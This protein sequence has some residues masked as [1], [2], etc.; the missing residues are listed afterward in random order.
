MTRDHARVVGA[1]LATLALVALFPHTASARQS[2]ETTPDHGALS[3]TLVPKQIGGEA[4]LLRILRKTP[5]VK[6]AT[7]V[8]APSER[9]A[10]AAMG[11]LLLAGSVRVELDSQATFEKLIAATA[12]VASVDRNS[13]AI[14]QATPDPIVG[15]QWG[16][17]NR[18]VPQGIFLDAVSTLFVPAIIGEDIHLPDTTLADLKL[19]I[20]AILDTGADLDHPDLKDSFARKPGECDTLTLYQACLKTETR[21]KCD[22][23]YAKV[24]TDGNGYPMDCVG[25]NLTAGPN[26]AT[27]VLGDPNTTDD[28]GHGTHLAGIIAATAGN[29]LGGRGAAPN[30]RILPVKVIRSAPNSPIRP[31]ADEP[32]LPIEATLRWTQGFADIIARGMLYAIRSGAQVINMSLAWPA[33]VDSAVMRRMVALAQARGILVV[34]AAGNDSTDSRVLPCAYPGVVCV[35]SH[36]SDG[37]FSHFSNYGS[38]I[39]LSAPGTRILSTWP[40]ALRAEVYTRYNGFELKSGTSMAAPYVAAAAAMLLG[41]G[42]A[43]DEVYA[44]LMT[45]TR[46]VRPSIHR[47]EDLTQ[48]YARSGNLDIAGAIAV[49]A[50]PLILPS[51]KSVIKAAWDR[52]ATE[53]QVSLKLRNFWAHADRVTI[54]ARL[55]SYDSV[56]EGARGSIVDSATSLGLSLVQTDFSIPSWER[57]QERTIDAT[58]AIESPDFDGRLSIELLIVADGRE[59]RRIRLPLEIF[60][61]IA[62]DTTIAGLKILPVVPGAGGAAISPRAQLRTVRAGDPALPQEYVAVEKTGSEL[63]LT[64]IKPTSAGFETSPTVKIP[65]PTGEFGQMQRVA[66]GYVALLKM[67]GPQGSSRPVFRFVTLDS[68]LAILRTLDFDNKTSLVAERF[69]WLKVENAFVPAWIGFGTTPALDRPR[70]DPWRRNVQDFP[71]TR[72]YFLAPEGLREL[73]IA[74]TDDFVQTLAPGDDERR[75]GVVPVVIARGN[76]YRKTFFTARVRGRKLTDI[77]PIEM[78]T[79]RMLMGIPNVGEVTG[80]D[81]AAG[82]QPATYFADDSAQGA[83]RTTIVASPNS[84]TARA[85]SFSVES[86]VVTDSVMRVIGAYSSDA[87]RA[88]LDSAFFESHYDL[89]YKDIRSGDVASTSLNRFSFIPAFIFGR[90][91]IPVVVSGAVGHIPAVVVPTEPGD[92]DGIEVIVPKREGATLRLSRPA[93]LRLAA[94]PGCTALGNPVLASPSAPS[95]TLFFCGDRFIKAPFSN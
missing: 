36:G 89:I 69:L 71:A 41:Q 7:S 65:L 91:Y 51:D 42:L 77:Q 47:G 84:S 78:S 60:V 46:P 33:G 53:I 76:D 32:P 18:G 70:F 20:V 44:R 15:E 2:T 66:D 68:R 80:L 52:A 23:K 62:K 92:S 79:Y 24:D 57:G 28:Q 85:Q 19:I 4:A 21:R 86:R 74:A 90:S 72:F 54:T 59:P 6:S 75:Q 45:S 12:P 25:W 40:T 43:A 8:F 34:A 50:Q 88:Q 29:G 94:Q 13:L 37:A 38:Y 22:D 14:L 55:R 58:L 27:G 11:D 82:S 1:A 81:A 31:Q 17:K 39:D 61:P 9:D 67:A 83:L 35:G 5:G 49:S 26:I 10:V 3:A 87:S 16:L 95:A 63:R 30:A 48:K 64:L 56:P 73:K 93:R